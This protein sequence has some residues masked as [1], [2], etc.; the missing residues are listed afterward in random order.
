MLNLLNRQLRKLGLDEATPPNLEQWCQLIERIKRTY[1]QIDQDRYLLE[2]SLVISSDEMLQLNENLRRASQSELAIER[3]KLKDSLER[4]QKL[5]LVASKAR[6][7]VVISDA[8]GRA[9]WVNDGFTRLSGYMSE[10]VIGRKPGELL[11]GPDTDPEAVKFVGERL[12]QRERVSTEILNYSKNGGAYWVSLEIEPVFDEQ[13]QLTNFI[14]TYTD[15]TERRAYESALRR[16]KEEAEAANR[17]KSEF[18]ANMSHE[19]RTPLN[20]ILGFTNV[21]LRD[22]D[23]TNS[24]RTDFLLTVIDS[25]KHL[26]SLVNDLLDL[27]KVESRQLQIERIAC[28][29][30]RILADVVSTLRVRAQE[31]DISL[32]YEWSGD[33]P[34]QIESDPH[35]IKQLLLN[36]IGNAIKFTQQGGVSVDAS[37]ETR[38]SDGLLKFVVTDTGI[39]IS[40]DKLQSIFDPFVQ[41]DNSVTR[42]FGGTGLGL[43]ISRS[44]AESMGGELTVSSQM[45]VGSQF[46]V[47]IAIGEVRTNPHAE[48]VPSNSCGDI[49]KQSACG[50]D[51]T[52][53]RV[54]VVDDGVTNRKLIQLLL[55]R[56]GAE[57]HTAENGKIA[58][59][60][61]TEQPFDIVLMDMQMPIM[62]GYTAT[63]ELRRRG[64]TRPIVALT[65]H[66]MK[67]DREKC[68][69]A[70]CSDYLSKP[71]DADALIA[72][73]AELAVVP[74]D[75]RGLVAVG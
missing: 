22:D 10:D 39:G 68:E 58:L 14:A 41:A 19:I 66:A 7:G 37:V 13:G 65:A 50:V 29:P 35:R 40:P 63:Q 72:K 3:N 62:D 54:L 27:A 57:I 20:A 60:Q 8:A 12:A 46:T 1:A 45:G 5:S 47:T 24:Q 71:I 69:Q 21:L 32:D 64:F 55:E 16:A 26:L 38:G 75:A 36:L 43:A 17:A 31:R 6:Y 34:E 15:I 53:V 74:E 61:A 49:V 42:R 25:G 51:L 44:I 48:A 11:Q 56:R 23:G 52:G 9:E 4:I 2:R 67:G 70:G 59:S 28:S 18:L 30:H 33:I 73:V